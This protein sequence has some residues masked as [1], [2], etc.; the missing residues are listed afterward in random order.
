[1]ESASE[2]LCLDP[3]TLHAMCISGSNLEGKMEAAMQ[4][5]TGSAAT[6]DSSDLD[7]WR[8]RRRCPSFAALKYKMSLEMSEYDCLYRSMG[9]MDENGNE[10]NATISADIGSLDNAIGA[11]LDPDAIGECV[12]NVLGVMA[13]DPK[14]VRCAGQYTE[15]QTQVL[16]EI[17]VKMASYECFSNIFAVACKNFIQTTYVDPMLSSFMPM[18][19]ET[20]AGR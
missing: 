13:D 6:R 2:G 19:T 14:Y 11:Q 10:V 7:R 18:G 16:E 20:S 8:R 4:C 3:M 1:M 9:W 5:F 17:A 15:T 12:V